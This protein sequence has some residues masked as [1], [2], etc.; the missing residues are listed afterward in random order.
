MAT[1][2]STAGPPSIHMIPCAQITAKCPYTLQ[3]DAPVPPHNCPF[4]WGM[5]TP[6]NTRFLGP[7]GVLN[8]N[9]ISI[10]AAVFAGLTSVADRQ[11]DRPTDHATSSATVTIGRIY[12]LVLRCGLKMNECNW[13]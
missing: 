2:L 8:P 9:S 1:S 3:W 5:G 4:P 6:S 12:V 11:T 7:T 10:G 13:S